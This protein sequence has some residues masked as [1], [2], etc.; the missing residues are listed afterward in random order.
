MQYGESTV[1]RTLKDWERGCQHPGYLCLV[2]W[3]EVQE[4]DHKN[5]QEQGLTLVLH[6]TDFEARVPGFRSTSELKN[7]EKINLSLPWLFHL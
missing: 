2:G 4:Q 1:G 6:S 7:L 5:W 3:I